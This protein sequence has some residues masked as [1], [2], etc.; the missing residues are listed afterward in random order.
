MDIINFINNSDIPKKSQ[1]N[2]VP[3]FSQYSK[4][5]QSKCSLKYYMLKF[6]TIKI[7]LTMKR[8]VVRRIMNIPIVIGFY[9]DNNSALS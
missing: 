8:I 1:H 2:L 7:I 9:I 6:V 5:D 3:R 4:I